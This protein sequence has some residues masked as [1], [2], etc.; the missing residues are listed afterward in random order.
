M[1]TQKNGPLTVPELVELQIM[2]RLWVLAHTAE[3]DML[4]VT[5]RDGRGA[6][7]DRFTERTN[8]LCEL[9]R[10]GQPRDAL[11]LTKRCLKTK[12]ARLLA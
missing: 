1:Q 3:R 6:A 11:R 5:G 4:R 9:M 10:T 12:V 2:T 8:R 7:M